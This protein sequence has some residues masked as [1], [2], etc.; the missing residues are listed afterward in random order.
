MRLQAHVVADEDHTGDAEALLHIQQRLAD[1]PLH[2]HIQRVVGSS[3]MMREG[4]STIAMM[5]N[6]L[7]HAAAQLVGVHVID[8]GGQPHQGEEVEASAP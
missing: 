5:Q 1:D 7:L 3:A 8:A 2:H 6:V 4:L